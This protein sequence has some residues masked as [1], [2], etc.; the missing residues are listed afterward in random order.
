MEQSGLSYIPLLTP[1][2]RS[3]RVAVSEVSSDNDNFPLQSSSSEYSPSDMN[4][5]PRKLSL[6]P[7]LRRCL[8]DIPKAADREQKK[9]SRVL[10]SFEN[11]KALEHR[12][13][14]KNDLLKQ[15]A[16]KKLQ[17]E[18]KKAAVLKEKAVKK[19]QREEKKIAAQKEKLKRKK[20]RTE[21]HGRNH[22]KRFPDF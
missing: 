2:K 7:I 15:K 10:T 1:T 19:L 11:L 9:S 17:R 16:A 12:E 13:K 3:G 4:Q 5:L 22:Y 6:S 18:E 21:K 20:M 14:E 8:P